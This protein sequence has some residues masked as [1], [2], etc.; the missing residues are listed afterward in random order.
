MVK[1]ADVPDLLPLICYFNLYR[2]YFLPSYFQFYLLRDY[3]LSTD[4]TASQ[5]ATIITRFAD[6]IIL[7]SVIFFT[8]Q[9]ISPASQIQT[10]YSWYF[11]FSHDQFYLLC[12]YKHS[13]VGIFC[14]HISNFTHDAIIILSTDG[15][16]PL[17]PNIFTR[18]TVIS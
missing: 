13:T 2:W 16:F 6:T 8:T 11:P 14:F 18:C 7:Q 3:I 5:Y 4:G 1:F 9:P 10:F 17:H 15:K 12:R